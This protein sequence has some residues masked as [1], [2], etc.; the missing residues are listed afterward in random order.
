MQNKPF[1]LLVV[2][3]LFFTSFAPFAYADGAAGVG[4]G[5]G[6]AG[7]QPAQP[8]TGASSAPTTPS[9]PKSGYPASDSCP[10]VMEISAA[11]RERLWAN[12][13]GFLPREINDLSEGEALAN[14]LSGK[15]G[16]FTNPVT[17][18]YSPAATG[19]SGIPLT[20]LASIVNV[21]AREVVKSVCGGKKACT[22][23]YLDADGNA[24]TDVRV[25]QEVAGIYAQQVSEKRGKTAAQ[26]NALLEQIRGY[27]L[28]PAGQQAATIPTPTPPIYSD[29]KIAVSGGTLGKNEFALSDLFKEKSVDP[30]SC[31]LNEHIAGRVTYMALVTSNTAFCN[32]GD[33][34][35]RDGKF[36]NPANGGQEYD[37]PKNQYFTSSDTG[38]WINLNG[39]SHFVVPSFFEDWL[40]FTKKWNQIDLMV[41]MVASVPFVV[42][43]IAPTIKEKQRE[44]DRLSERLKDG[45][46][47]SSDD[48]VLATLTTDF[49]ARYGAARSN[50]LGEVRSKLAELS[51]ST[52]PQDILKAKELS[53]AIA[54]G[55]IISASK[56]GLA[57][58]VDFP[59]K[60]E[61]AFFKSVTD[62]EQRVTRDSISYTNVQS[63]E[64]ELTELQTKQKAF[65][66]ILSGAIRRGT[67]GLVIAA[68]WLGPARLAFSSA[69]RMLFSFG[70][71]TT[72]QHVLL[73]AGETIGKFRE[74]T[75][76]LGAG[77]MGELVQQMTGMGFFPPQ[78][79][80][81]A[82]SLFFINKPGDDLAES[83]SFTTVSSSDGSWLVN[84]RWEKDSF[85]TAFEDLRS[86]GD[87]DKYTSMQLL[88]YNNFPSAALDRKDAANTLSYIAGMSVPW[89][90][91]YSLL[92]EP[93]YGT[94]GLVLALLINQEIVKVDPDQFRDVECSK[95]A[96]DSYKKQYAASI[97]VGWFSSYFLPMLGLFKTAWIQKIVRV[98][99][100]GGLMGTLTV[101]NGIN[102]INSLNLASAWQWWI[103]TR[104][105]NYVTACKDKQ[106]LIF[107]YQEIKPVTKK[108]STAM[109]TQL[110]SITDALAN[111]KLGQA[112][113]QA[114]APNATPLE[115]MK[116][117]LNVKLGMK[118]QYGNIQPDDIFYLQIE[119]SAFSLKSRLWDTLAGEGC[120]FEENYQSGDQTARFT[121]DGLNFY[122]KQGRL[123]ASFND[124]AWRLRSLGRLRS[125]ELARVIMPN[126]LI[127]ARLA[128]GETP[129]LEVK[130]GGKPTLVGSCATADCLK[131]RIFDVTGRNVD[132]AG[133]LSPFLGR[134]SSV[135]TDE[136][137]AAVEQNAVRFTR[138]VAT[139][140]AGGAKKGSEVSAPSVEDY[141][142]L[143]N[144][145]EG[146]KLTV[147]GDGMVFV[148][149]PPGSTVFNNSLG[150][151][152]T[153][154][155]D[156][157]KIEFDPA[158]GNLVLFIYVLADELAANVNKIDAKPT[159]NT[160]PDGSNVSAIKMDTG[161]K[162]GLDDSF[163]N[164]LS[165]IQG[166]GGMQSWEDENHLFYL[167]KDANGNSI[168]RVVDKKTGE[169]TDYKITGPITQNPDGSITI[170]TDKGNFKFS[171]G[172]DDATGAPILHAEGP[173]LTDLAAALL[174]ARGQNGI[175]TFNP[176][177]GAIS[178]YNGQDIPLSPEFAKKGISFTGDANGNT[179]GVPQ[180]NLFGATRGGTA[181]STESGG[182]SQPF[183]LPAW[184][185]DPLL[186]AA[187]LA[188]ILGLV[189]VIRRRTAPTTFY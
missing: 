9:A 169:A 62:V 43:K 110:K 65:Q 142:K 30:E 138:L 58:D 10:A 120:R 130:A 113:A 3:A 143:A 5:A 79:A 40:S 84:T 146:S 1:A 189:L 51:L 89:I 36:I 13:M 96:L 87:R 129:F 15:A 173:G 21:D 25:P 102:I 167:T 11:D 14:Q 152:R 92:R 107:A 4:A 71:R 103:M 26:T 163:R 98:T 128:C 112:A 156:R 161:E 111:L 8:K 47:M 176:S 164:A 31:L 115:N 114:A 76:V 70:G 159:E 34:M 77:R 46:R 127:Q 83:K 185:R 162:T 148:D 175:M 97:G 12:T 133:D 28:L 75:D 104:A 134:V 101:Q 166:D 48:Q 131:A 174:A 170:P 172:K 91:T 90:V 182:G 158:T 38:V 18:P 24:L 32:E 41:S 55:K 61:L 108:K 139:G 60:T 72:P 171:F 56:F 20:M 19:Q 6:A 23:V 151:L 59:D 105:Q 157:G 126:K 45:Q 181:G 27:G 44:I 35:C 54:E 2:F 7:A 150:E 141:A 147:R 66:S 82:G 168:L 64:A 184:P 52:K 100:Q 144:R 33:A 135:D 186:A 39:G 116:E 74:A 49:Q 136:G 67:M 180:E 57:A 140:G 187:L 86:F 37:I 179:I 118:N 16:N 29:L 125:Q 160:L 154:I 88:S 149:G 153:I 106:H 99:Q 178:I 119:R 132:A 124:Y 78:K 145:L 94:I 155:G 63:L 121:I 17:N 85:V 137:I 183:S 22:D 188:S 50:Q 95:A 69:N 81:K 123:T 42:Q 117:T 68:I 177:T 93:G 165:S 73:F 53:G 109:D 80:Y 122:D